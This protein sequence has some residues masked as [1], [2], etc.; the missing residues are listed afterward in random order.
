MSQESDEAESPVG[1]LG[2][3]AG[4]GLKWSVVGQMVT[5]VAS[6]AMGLILA[7]LLAPSDFGIYAVA[8][9]ATQFVMTVKDIGIMAATVQWRGKL[10]DMAPTASLM[11]LISAV[12]LYGVFWLGAPAFAELAGNADAAP[13][14]QLLTAV[15]LVEAVTA[16][17]TAA[18]MRRF[19][20]DRLTMSLLAGFVVNAAVAITLAA[21]GAGPYSFA[22]GQVAGAV[23]TGV[24][25]LFAAKMPFRLGLDRA[26][27]VKLLKFGIPSAAGTG[28]EAVLLNVGYIIVGDRLGTVLLGFYLLAF[29]V[30]SWVPGLVGTAVRFVSIPGFSRLAERGDESLS[31][32]VRRAVPMLFTVVLPI[33]VLMATL[34][35]PLVSFLYG[36]RWD[37]SGAVL[38]YLAVVML[39]RM[40]TALAFDILTSQGATRATVWMNLGHG[41]ALIPAIIIGTDLDGIRG[42]AIGQMAAAVL[43]GLPLAIYFLQRE[44]V[45][46]RPVLPHLVRPA[47]AGLVSGAVA[48]LVRPLAGD[49]A[50]FELVLAGGAGLIAYILIVVPWA[51]LR[52]FTGR[53][54]HFIP[55]RSR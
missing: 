18:L 2:R 45:D 21:S 53:A 5:K 3:Q 55:A 54:V 27:A 30:S 20:Q 41:V 38:R 6:F 49:V 9:A 28:L 1:S 15:I 23:V 26:I 7:R 40:L 13:V 44:K 4:R 8:L 10:E 51:Q 11:A 17:R 16:V 50:F 32:G 34:A 46:L 43:V 39:V 52:E 36:E 12:L 37:A 35:H 48:L 19:Q 33:A 47:V 24:F 22:W 31:N 42:A 14:V 25:V 29:N